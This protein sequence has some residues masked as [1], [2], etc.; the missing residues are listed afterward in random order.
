MAAHAASTKVQSMPRSRDVYDLS[1]TQLAV[2]AHDVANTTLVRC[3]LQP[4][5]ESQI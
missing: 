3:Q 4:S 2:L 5:Y 1:G